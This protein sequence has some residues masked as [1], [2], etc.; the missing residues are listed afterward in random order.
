MH[1]G[2][3]VD[4]LRDP[5][6]ARQDGN[7]GNEG[8]IAHELIARGPGVPS[9][10]LQFSLIGGEAE[11]RIERGGLACAVRSDE[12]EDAALFDAQIDAVERDG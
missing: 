10:D 4:S 2:D 1:A 5:D 8:D 7:I 9:E 12:S 11:N 3:V 6:P